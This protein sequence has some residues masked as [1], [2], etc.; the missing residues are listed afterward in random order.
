MCGIAGVASVR[1]DAGLESLARR[2]AAKLAH[3]G[4]DGEGIFVAPGQEAALAHKRLAIIDLQTGAQPMTDPDG[5]RTVVFNGE[6]YNYREQRAEL[7]GYRFAT[8]SDTEVILA[9]HAQPGLDPARLRG[10]FAYALWDGQTRRLDLYRDRFGQ[11]PL[12]YAEAEE[13]L[14]FASELKALLAVLPR[15]AIDRV[16]L[17]EY[18]ALGYVPGTRTI[19]RGI[20]Q[21][22]PGHALT[23]QAGRVQVT[24]YWRP[25]LPNGAPG[26]RS[27]DEWRQRVGGL[28]N[29]AVREQLM[30]DVPLGAF[31]SGGLDSSLA[32][33][34]CMPHVARPFHTFSVRAEGAPS[35]D[36]EAARNVAAWLGTE[37]HEEILTCPEP[38]ELLSLLSH[39][40]S[41][42]ADSSLIPTSAVSRAARRE[43][44]VALSGDGGD[45]VFGGYHVYGR[46]ARMM[47]LSRL[48]V[49]ELLAPHLARTWRHGRGSGT[50]AA[51]SVPRRDR[52]RRLAS[53]LWDDALEAV[54]GGP[55]TELDQ[56]REE[57]ALLYAVPSPP[58]DTNAVGTAQWI[59]S[60]TYLPS[61]I[62]LK[63]DMASMLHSLE[64][65]SPFLDHRLWEELVGLPSDLRMS[66]GIGKQLLRRIAA[67]H[68]PSQVIEREKV[69]FT[70]PMRAWLDGPLRPLLERHLRDGNSPVARYLDPAA[71][72][73]QLA[74]AGPARDRLEFLF[75]SLGA[76]AET[77]P[78]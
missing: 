64:V 54:S 65:R 34:L 25:A 48:P 24:P 21:V 37:H 73:A 7:A 75:I 29:R 72:R 63:V 27:A 23:F 19:Y 71:I 60:T 57:L 8:D 1:P 53:L 26:W 30:S 51:L 5:R 66:G 12:Y 43:V 33:A 40:D 42:F 15:P 61:D 31:L 28:L 39:F 14:Y 11:K 56:A 70:V 44:T 10:M 77:Q 58:A 62:L 35:P 16:A 52:Y 22:P 74:A 45:E 2:M 67:P 3:R 69:G 68:V 6:I 50:L 78:V 49:I 36:A 13:R 38:E 47:A 17:I 4:P 41:P 9:A 20:G 76:W 55:S 18:V 46:F 59:D 32:V